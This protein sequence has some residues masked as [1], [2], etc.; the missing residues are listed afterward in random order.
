M[1][2][3]ANIKNIWGT[4][5]IAQKSLNSIL[6]IAGGSLFLWIS[7]INAGRYVWLWNCWKV[8]LNVLVKWI[9][10][11]NMCIM[12]TY[13]SSEENRPPKEGSSSMREKG[14]CVIS[15]WLQSF[16]KPSLLEYFTHLQTDPWKIGHSEHRY[17]YSYHNRYIHS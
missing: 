17:I 12:C 8:V 6:Y 10:V 14:A 2:A 16:S 1:D 15:R 5:K 11:N 7:V 4:Q 3:A 9:N 13:H